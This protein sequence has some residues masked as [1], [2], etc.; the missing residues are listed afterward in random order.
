MSIFLNHFIGFFLP[1]SICFAK[2]MSSICK[3]FPYSSLRREACVNYKEL[4]KKKHGDGLWMAELAAVKACVPVD[5]S[6]LG[7][8]GIILTN[9]G[10]ALSL[11]GTDSENKGT[12]S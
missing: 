2:C 4:W 12:L 6:L 10:A 8:S 5:M 1:P 7:S 11:N 9:E 3:L